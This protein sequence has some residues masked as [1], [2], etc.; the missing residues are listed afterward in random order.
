MYDI[1]FPPAYSGADWAVAVEVID[2]TT[3]QPMTGLDEA[4]I[5]L[6][7]NDDCNSAMLTGSTD[8]GLVTVPQVGVIQ[9]I[10]PMARLSGWCQGKTYSVGCRITTDGG[11]TALFTGSLPFLD[12]EF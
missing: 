11:T 8:D 1:S 3:N 5:E 9:W 6:R 10:I 4:L 7:V 12:S 2:P